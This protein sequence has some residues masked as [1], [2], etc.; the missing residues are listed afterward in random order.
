M[1]IKGW[2]LSMGLGIAAGAVT[3]MML[4]KSNPVRKAANKAA[5]T[6]EDA[7]CR[8]GDKIIDSMGM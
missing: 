6:V 1:A 3:V 8:A 5:C 2:A 4:P 7:A